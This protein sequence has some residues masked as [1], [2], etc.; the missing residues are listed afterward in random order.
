MQPAEVL[1]QRRFQSLQRRRF[2]AAKNI[3]RINVGVPTPFGFAAWK[4]ISNVY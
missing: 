3:I 4:G 2:G 1:E